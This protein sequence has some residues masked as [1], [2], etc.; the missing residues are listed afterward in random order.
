MHKR[1]IQTIILLF[2]PFVL[3]AFYCGGFRKDPKVLINE[4]CSNN[5]SVVKDA[6]GSYSDCIEL[7]NPGKTDV[8]L[9]GCY[10]T[11]DE[12]EPEKYSLEG[13]AA[14]AGGYTLIWL[15]RNAAF[16]VSREGDRL[17]LADVGEGCFL[18]QV[19]VPSLSYDTSYGRIGD[20]D[21][22]WSVMTA[23]PGRSNRE[24]ELLP[25]VSLESP[26]FEKAG[27][28]YEEA[29]DLHLYSPAGDKIYYTLDGS[30]PCAS[31]SVYREPIPIGDPTLS[32]NRYINRDDLAPNQDYKPAFP[33]D[34]AVVVRA[35]C[36]N[37]ATDQIS[38]IVTE[39]Y[40]IGYDARPEYDD[41]AILSLTADPEDLFGADTGIYGNGA[42]FEA[43]LA[44]GGIQDGQ[45]LDSYT[46][47]DGE[48]RYRYMASN[49]FREG[50]EWERTAC[51][52][53]F[54]E[55]HSPLFT[56]DTGIR[57]SGNS[58]RSA[59]QKSF[60][61]FARD[62]YGEA[63]NLPAAF[64][65]DDILY[66]SVKL[67]NGGGNMD[68]VK[69]LDAFLE[70][71]AAGRS[72]SIQD[73]KPC[74]LFLNGEYWGLYNLRERYTPEYL[75][76]RYQLQPENIMLIKAGNAVTSPEETLASWQYMLD[77]VTQCD[78]VYDDTYALAEELVDMQSLIDYCCI[79]LYLDNRDVAFG[80]N[81]AAWR[82]AQEG[83]PYGDEKWRFMLYDLDECVHP[84]SNSPENRENWMAEHPL[85]NEPA[86]MSLLDN[87][88]FRRRFCISF[89]DIANTVFSY[90]KI[91]PLLEEWRDRYETQI[92]K[93]HQAF[94]GK[95]YTAADFQADV[96]L[97]DAFF[98]DRLPFAME[99]LARTF[100]LTGTLTK[101]CIGTDTPEGGVITVNTAQ[102]EDCGAWEGYYYSD[103]PLS[104][105]VQARE[106]YR[107]IGWQG[108]VSA[109]D[110]DTLLLNPDGEEIIL[111]ALFEKDS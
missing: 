57:I 70:T 25:A 4:V 14:P 20:G 93:D 104:V 23:T 36:Y 101:I 29:F 62:I 56:Q 39:T 63:E 90:G 109:E 24:A 45:I 107:F 31:S 102:L 91:H 68:G 111:R 89:M 41:L 99:S 54:D 13:L 51:L 15:D 61:I 33:V 35:A 22:R 18:D 30:K 7:Y 66:S 85:L 92:V 19:I 98:A 12:K 55:R 95:D 80:Y 1:P 76:A 59:R 105:T 84:D 37:A 88:T 97:V 11:D 67:R 2:I 43:Y 46:D 110:G 49:A 42:G 5:F 52:S 64:F 106:G 74:V 6:D 81:T 69:F 8:S 17:F 50:R 40:F 60:N 75:A 78:L 79:N 83:T 100:G 53:Y 108:N 21:D 27:G 38:E 86:V 96:A 44:E 58:T 34:K 16:R 32:E 71:A 28:F 26:V 73:Y 3:S 72:V 94:Y 48:I 10:L 82:A 87:E 47:A 77:V 103:F 9:D 65:D